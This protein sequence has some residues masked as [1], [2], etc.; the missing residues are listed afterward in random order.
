VKYTFEITSSC[1]FPLVCEDEAPALSKEEQAEAE[2]K[3]TIVLKPDMS[4]LLTLGIIGIV[5]GIMA[6]YG[7]KKVKRW[8]AKRNAPP[9][10]RE[11]PAESAQPA[12]IAQVGTEIRGMDVEA[13]L[14]NEG[15]M[16]VRNMRQRSPKSKKYKHH[17]R[18]AVFEADST[19]YETPTAAVQM[20]PLPRGSVCDFCR[21]DQL[22]CPVHGSR[23][24]AAQGQQSPVFEADYQ[25]EG[26]VS[27]SADF[28][29]PTKPK[30]ETRSFDQL[31]PKDWA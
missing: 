1:S 20:Q 9:P 29:T 4:S 15:G 3:S 17:Q 7:I 24:A 18:S 28:A 30:G 2:K 26:V 16:K 12:G 14:A 31:I 27:H 10:S 8:R 21:V 13:A 25:T 11:S 23:N 19:P 22:R 5:G 6:H